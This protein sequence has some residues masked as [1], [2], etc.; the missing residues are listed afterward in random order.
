M[1]PSEREH[2]QISSN[3][4]S[5]NF[6]MRL[7]RMGHESEDRSLVFFAEHC[8]DNSITL[9][10]DTTMG[11][12]QYLIVFVCLLI[13]TSESASFSIAGTPAC[14]D[15]QN[16]LILKGNMCTFSCC[17]AN[18]IRTM[19]ASQSRKITCPTFGAAD[20]TADCLVNGYAYPHGTVVK[21]NHDSSYAC[22]YGLMVLYKDTD[23]GPGIESV[24][25]FTM[26]RFG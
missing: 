6:P 8:H 20:K 18:Q 25:D 12:M 14:T 2:F 9:F 10:S 7:D 16:G 22:I 26:V 17:L 11:I 19:E 5:S 13:A 24:T 3:K 15:D 21:Y 4:L 1:P 23:A